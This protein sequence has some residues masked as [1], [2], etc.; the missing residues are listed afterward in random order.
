MAP[1][2]DILKI[3]RQIAY[4]QRKIRL[5]NL[6]KGI[7]I[8]Y[9]ASIVS[10]GEASVTIRTEKIQLVTMYLARE[11]FI[12]NVKFPHLVRA[13]V[14]LVDTDKVNAML[15]HFLY[16]P[17]RLGELTRARIHPGE[18]VEGAVLSEQAG[19][20]SGEM[21]DISLDGVAVLVQ[22]KTVGDAC[23]PGEAVGVQL[24]LPRRIASAE[25]QPL[26]LRGKIANVK[27]GLPDGK[28]RIGVEL[29]PN[30]PARLELAQFIS[31]RQAEL[32]REIRSIYE[33]V[34]LE[35]KETS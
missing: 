16:N 25:R 23:M 35:T 14:I 8:S 11:T 26:Q 27:K 32:L 20:V 7:P 6:Y 24:Q 29:E 31:Q 2:D 5:L 4:E 18:R 34:S 10:I 12:Q 22:E 17:E 21:V 1:T 15:S 13:G 30:H 19:Q 9:A 33:L 28:C 3:F